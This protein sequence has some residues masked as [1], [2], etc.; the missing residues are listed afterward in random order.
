MNAVDKATTTIV[1][2]IDSAGDMALKLDMAQWGVISM[3][4]LIFAMMLMRG[5]VIEGR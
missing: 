5:N 2:A 1:R 3:I 4:I